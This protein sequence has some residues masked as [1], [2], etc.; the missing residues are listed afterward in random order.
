LYFVTGISG[1]GKSTVAKH[2]RLRGY[3]AHELQQIL[4]WHKDAQAAYRRAGHLVVDATKP[5]DEVVDRVLA[6][7]VNASDEG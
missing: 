4:G 6:L 7:T 2:L 3:D 5:I 1:S